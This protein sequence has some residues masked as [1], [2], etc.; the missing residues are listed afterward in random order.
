M[1]AIRA[2][3][4]RRAKEHF[5]PPGCREEQP[6]WKHFEDM[7]G[8]AV[9]IID[10]IQVLLNI[11]ELNYRSEKSSSQNDRFGARKRIWRI[12]PSDA[13]ENG[14]PEWRTKDGWEYPVNVEEL[15]DS[16]CA[17]I[18]RP[19]LAH[20][21]LDWALLSGWLLGSAHNRRRDLR[22]GFLM[23]ES[24]HSLGS[25]KNN[26]GKFTE[27]MMTRV[28]DPAGA[29]QIRCDQLKFS[30]T[31]TLVCVIFSIVA[32]YIVPNWWPI[33]VT[34]LAT[35]LFVKR[36]F[37]RRL[38]RFRRGLASVIEH[39]S[40]AMKA[41][42]AAWA[43]TNSQAIELDDLSEKVKAAEAVGLKLSPG[44]RSLLSVIRGRHGRVLA[45]S[46]S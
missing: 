44:F 40:N 26:F 34:V 38:N 5:I 31:H 15:E 19:W 28:D 29:E 17:Y 30:W 6:S 7:V 1:P 8:E 24:K 27:R 18:A 43:E 4:V 42:K 33:V 32:I 21:V 2:E 25:K 41:I 16:I 22:S 14:A 37:E 13:V 9:E 23:F 45:V 10:L 12:W 46:R 36:S 35:W 11:P 39:E 20:P 3:A